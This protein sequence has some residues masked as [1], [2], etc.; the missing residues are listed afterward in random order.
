MAGLDD[1]P[2][3]KRVRARTPATPPTL[4]KDELKALALECGADDCGIVSLDDPALAEERPHIRRAFPSARI[5]VSIVRRMHR[6]P[7]R[8]PLRSAANSEFHNVSHEVDDVC[9]ALVRRLEDLGIT[10]LNPPMAFP[11]EMDGFSQRGWIVSHKLVAEAAGMGK[12]GIHR[13]II[14]PKFGSFILLGTVLID[15]DIEA[16]GMP[17]DYNPC[18]EC[19]LC[20]VACPVG[21]IKPDGYFDFSSCLNHNYQQFMGGFTNW[22]EDIADSRSARDY[23][24]RHPPSE[25]LQRWQSLS[26]GP[27]Y[28]AAYCLAVCPAGE[29]VLGGFLADRKAHV[30][31]IVKPLQDKKETLYVV[32]NSDAAEHA[33]QRFP[34]KTLR[35]VRNAARAGSIAQFLFGMRLG[36]QRGK[37][38]GLNATYHFVFTG[39]EPA[40]ATVLIRNQTLS[41]VKG[42]EGR[43]DLRVQADSGAW[44]RFLDGRL[45]ILRA[46]AT[47]AIRIKGPPRLMK[48][49]A[50]C[51]PR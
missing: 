28:N 17:L 5:A 4:T 49:F 3:A 39:T 31:A 15:V 34:H 50:A 48:A 24:D 26:Y 47:R 51:F 22:I 13:S 36:F 32:G 29:D 27:N 35:H 23:S 42:L 9:R 14:H 7:V 2:I 6:A 33:A 8:S 46:L 21:A 43:A 41:V 45:S 16:P 10:A 20:V 1:H 38:K 11:M 12:R 25:T 30:D 40:E 44:L 19:K 18:F 37:A